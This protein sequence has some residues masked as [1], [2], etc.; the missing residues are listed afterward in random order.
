MIILNLRLIM[1]KR[2]KHNKCIP[3]LVNRNRA[4]T[5]D[6][7]QIVVLKINLYLW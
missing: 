6:I 3:Y 5:S 1:I 4:G 2:S 7:K